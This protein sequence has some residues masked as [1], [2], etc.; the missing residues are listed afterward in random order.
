MCVQWYI[1]YR[2]CVPMHVPLQRQHVQHWEQ[3]LPVMLSTFVGTLCSG[4]H[5]SSCYFLTVLNWMTSH[6][7]YLTWSERT[8]TNAYTHIYVNMCMHTHW[9]HLLSLTDDE[10]GINRLLDSAASSTLFFN[11]SDPCSLSPGTSN[12]RRNWLELFIALQ[13]VREEY[14]GREKLAVG[15]FK[16]SI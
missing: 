1:L 3:D 8:Y 5:W 14:R 16:L 2:H 4:E 13:Q 9:E 6:S 15:S 12:K 11:I 10:T 7:V